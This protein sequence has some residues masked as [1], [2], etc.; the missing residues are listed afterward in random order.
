MRPPRPSL[1]A[2][3]C[4]L[5]V[6]SLALAGC[7]PTGDDSDE[8]TPQ[9]VSTN[10]ELA[11]NPD[12][13]TV[14]DIAYGTVDGQP[15]L[16]DACLP[17]RDD[18]APDAQVVDTDADPDPAV[19]ASEEDRPRA[20]IVVIHGGSWA[21]GD[22]ADIAWRAVCQWLASAG[23]PTFAINYRLAP[24]NPYPA[25]IEDVRTAIRWLRQAGQVTRFNL[26]PDRIGAFGGSAG[27]NLAAL[28]GTTADGDGSRVAAVVDLS[29]PIDLTGVAATDD[30]VPVQL[31]Y[32]GCATAD[33]C[34]AAEAASPNYAVDAD[35][36]PFFVAHSTREKIPLEQ[37]ELFVETLRDAGIDTEFV[38]VQGTLH[39][40]A[41]IDA[42]LKERIVQFFD[43]HLAA[44]AIPVD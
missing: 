28:L 35:D 5:A 29:G 7:G 3:V 11:T 21:R 43:D 34:P 22:K 18:E 41:M 42:A 1:L 4:A 44:P 38:T 16:L 33:D 32:L 24:T 15:L 9:I 8:V 25:A 12:I 37:S 36:P 17:P 26:D 20:S 6:G 2:V 27:G 10:P 31:A 13:P 19:E 14:E 39:S 30:F 40:I 23:Y